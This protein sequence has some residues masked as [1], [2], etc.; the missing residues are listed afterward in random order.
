MMPSR[1]LV[2]V[3]EE[4][5]PQ[6]TERERGVKLTMEAEWVADWWSEP[7]RLVHAHFR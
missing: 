5:H 7:L 1:N 2:K 3:H 4:L 6:H